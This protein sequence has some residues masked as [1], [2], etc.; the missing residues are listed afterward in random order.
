MNWLREAVTDSGT[1]KVSSKRVAVLV[2]S[3]SMS[4][5][6]DILAV[7]ALF[8]HDVSLA[9]GAVCVP[10][11]GLGGYSYVHGKIAEKALA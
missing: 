5:A 6:V 3:F 9:L 10:L 11:A 8:G 4:I 2:G 1:D 7:A